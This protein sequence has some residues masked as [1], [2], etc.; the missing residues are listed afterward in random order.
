M[1]DSFLAG[2]STIANEPQ[3]ESA[4]AASPSDINSDAIS[5][6]QSSRDATGSILTDQVATGLE[7]VAELAKMV[8]VDPPR[9]PEADFSQPDL[10][11]AVRSVLASEFLEYEPAATLT[12]LVYCS[13]GMPCAL[14]ASLLG[15]SASGKS[16]MAEQVAKIF[17]FDHIRFS[18]QISVPGIFA[19]KRIPVIV[20]DEL[21]PNL[22]FC[23]I[24]RQLISG[25]TVSRDLATSAGDS[26]RQTIEGPIAFLE[27]TLDGNT[28]EYQNCNRMLCIRLVATASQI[29]WNADRAAAKF[30]AT[31][32]AGDSRYREL[33]NRMAKWTQKVPRNTK[34]VFP[35]TIVTMVPVPSGTQLPRRITQVLNVASV[36][37]LLRRGEQTPSTLETGGNWIPGTEHDVRDA[38]R[39]I[40]K[41][42]VEDDG[43]TLDE[44]STKFL[45]LMSQFMPEIGSVPEDTPGISVGNI[46]ERL[47]SPRFDQPAGEIVDQSKRH[48][49]SS[50][51]STRRWTRRIVDRHLGILFNNGFVTRKPH[52]GGFGWFTTNQGKLLI[53]EDSTNTF[54]RIRMAMDACL[55]A[56]PNAD[57]VS[58]NLHAG[59]RDA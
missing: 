43:Q 9:P 4:E 48:F 15:P 23:R 21:V 28:Q 44:R 29:K 1:P 38:L 5:V 17:P 2:S 58:H 34:V 25:S 54:T 16:Y 53:Q 42:H 20:V 19:M 11:Q 36:I 47:N 26:R 40:T 6:K 18:S 35:A 49:N 13:G 31:G 52:K 50:R 55:P 22:D 56:N 41:A 32:L 10:Y 33:K 39:L 24:R 14:A 57:I 51:N 27:C 3:F 12:F 59:S 46:V 8:N 45:T 7:V 30:T 37:A